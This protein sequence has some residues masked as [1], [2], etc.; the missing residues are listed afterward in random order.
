MS[1]VEELK[2]RNVFRVAIAY[3]ALAWL[4]IEIADTLFPVFDAPEWSLRLLVILLAMG[5]L[6]SL[7]FSEQLTAPDRRHRLQNP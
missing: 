6:P 2:R 5:F 4:L 3:L 1:F 7:V